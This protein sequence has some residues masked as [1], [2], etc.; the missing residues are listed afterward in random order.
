[1]STSLT[2]LT[3]L[4][5][6]WLDDIGSAESLVE[7]PSD[8]NPDTLSHVAQ[9]LSNSI[10]KYLPGHRAVPGNSDGGSSDETMPI[11]ARIT[12]GFQH[13]FFAHQQSIVH[14]I[15]TPYHGILGMGSAF[16]TIFEIARR[17]M[18]RACAVA[19]ATLRSI[20]PEWIELLLRR[21]TGNGYDYVAPYYLLHKYDGTITNSLAYPLTR[22]LY[23]Q[24]IRQP[25]RNECGF[26]GELAAHYFNQHV[27]ESDLARSGIDIWM[28]TE[29][30]ASSARV[31]QTF[32]GTK[33]H[34]PKDPSPDRSA[35]LVGSSPY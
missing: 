9:A 25:I 27:R 2:P 8:N 35:M 3:T 13:F 4:T 16:R 12:I 18:T 21:I 15:V 26:S 32:L 1:M 17:L 7:I 11:V 5:E 14:W 28:T 31:C 19:D 24:R 33:I 6:A 23:G 29:A 10:A 30:I 22:A 20:L 34:N